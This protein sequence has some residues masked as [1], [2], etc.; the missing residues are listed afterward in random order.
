ELCK[1]I[2]WMYKNGVGGFFMHARGGLKTE[3]LGEKWFECI[4]VCSELAEK[5]GMEAYAYDENGWPSGFV[6][7]KLLDDIEN[8]DMYLTFT[9][10]KYD[11]NSFVSYDLSNESL[12]RVNSGEN[13]LNVFAHF[14]A[15]TVDILNPDVVDKFIEM[16]HEEYRKRDTYN[17]KGF[18]TDEPQ[19]YRWNTPYTKVLAP[20]FLKEY[21]EDI[22]NGLGLLF[23]EKQ[24]YRAFRYKYWKAMQSLMLENFAKK[25]YDWCEKYGYKLTGHYIEERFLAMQLCCCGGIMPFYEY[26]HIPGIDW[27]SRGSRTQIAQKQ[28]SSVAAQLG[29][30]QVISETYGCCGWDVTP[31]ELKEIA[32]SQYVGGVNLMCQH[33]MPYTEHGQRKRDYPAHYSPV[34]PWVKKNFKQFNDY[35]SYLGKLIAEST[36]FVNVGMFHP[37][38]SAYFAYKRYDNWENRYGFPEIENSFSELTNTL[39][40]KQINFHYIDETLLAKY[41]SVKNGKLILGNCEYEFLVFPNVHTMDKTTERILK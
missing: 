14:S 26:E 27:L 9:K 17:L 33:L 13:C 41:G 1:Q 5:L 16:T 12:V 38:R 23:V 20:Y 6:G 35:F 21:N 18:F 30:K 36:E 32:E 31:Q 40:E 25:I 4:K 10:G 39:I 3:Y 28:V 15:C 22:L 37:I 29:K 34:N 8:H 7:G 2:E 24:G 11:A 19:Y